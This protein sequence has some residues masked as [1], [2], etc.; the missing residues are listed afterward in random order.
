MRV[1]TATS[2]CFV[3]GC[4]DVSIDATRVCDGWTCV[5]VVPRVLIIVIRK[6][7][8]APNLETRGPR[9]GTRVHCIDPS[10]LVDHVGRSRL[11]SERIGLRR[12][13][14]ARTSRHRCRCGWARTGTVPSRS[15]K[16]VEG[17][18]PSGAVFQ[19]RTGWE[20]LVVRR[21]EMRANVTFSTVQTPFP[22]TS[23]A[24]RVAILR[25]TCVATTQLHRLVSFSPSDP[26]LSRLLVHVVCEG[27]PFPHVL[28]HVDEATREGDVC[29][30]LVW[31][32]PVAF[33]C[34]RAGSDPNSMEP[35]APLSNPLN[36]SQQMQPRGVQH[37]CTPPPRGKDTSGTRGTRTS[38]GRRWSSAL[39]G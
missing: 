13:M 17:V 29:G 1:F 21:G 26:F 28:Q 24:V 15:E 3:D 31:C 4:V 39:H 7:G 16:H 38:A 32:D 34:D 37:S 25:D 14:R 20:K 10:W 30:S 27:P 6:Q 18:H 19:R 33:V 9:V 2:H 8:V 23:V 11:E 5:D 35:R 22:I 36:E 12:R